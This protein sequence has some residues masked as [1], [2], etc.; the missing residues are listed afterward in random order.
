MTLIKKRKTGKI[1]S[2]SKGNDN[3]CICV[4]VCA[5]IDIWVQYLDIGNDSDPLTYQDT[6]LLNETIEDYLRRKTFYSG[7]F[8]QYKVTYGSKRKIGEV[9]LRELNVTRDK[10]L[11]VEKLTV[12]Y[13]AH[14]IEKVGKYA[15]RVEDTCLQLFSHVVKRGNVSQIFGRCNGEILTEET[16]LISVTTS[17][18][19]PMILDFFSTISRLKME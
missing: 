6:H 9:N 4:E 1:P 15:Y 18:N 13:Y 10:P 11:V 19:N 17:K 5:F 16:E 3:F 2:T 8:N 14:F 12:Y 7:D